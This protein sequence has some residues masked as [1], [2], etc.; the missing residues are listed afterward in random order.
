MPR[1]VSLLRTLVTFSAP[2]SAA[3][4]ILGAALA[5][6]CGSDSGT[7][8]VQP[9]TKE[10]G[11]DVNAGPAALEA[12]PPATIDAANRRDDVSSTVVFD[13]L[14][15]G[16]WTANGDVGSIAYSDI[17]H[18][19][20]LSEIAIGQNVTSV[21]L[22]PDYAWVAA[23]DRGAGTVA[24][25]DATAVAVRRTISLGTHPR[26]AVW[27][28]ADPRWLYV[29]MED[30][31]AVAVV[32]RTLGVLNHTVAVGRIPAGLAVSRLRRELTVMHRI[33]AAVTLLPLEG[34][35]AP[36]DQGVPP[37]DVPLADEPVQSDDTQ[38]SGKPFAFESLAWDPGGSVVWLPH[39]LLANHPPVQFQRNLFPAV[40]VVDLS[41]RS[42][43][44]T[45]PND[46]NGV[47]A[48]RKLLFSG[49]N[50]LDPTGNTSIVSQPCAAAI[51]PNGLVAYVVTC[52]SEDLLTFDVTSGIAI[53]LLRNLP[54]DHPTGLTLDDTG[55]RAFIVADQSHSLLTLDLAGGSPIGHARIIGGPLS[56]AA[57][58]PV[59]PELRA[60]LKL[61][62]EANSA[63]NALPT[64][65]NFW[66]S[67][68]GCHLD[69]FVSTNQRFF[70]AL[71]AL[72]PTTD[73]QIGHV[74]LTD[75]FST[76]PTPTSPTFN[77]H[78]VLVALLDQGGLVPD[79]TGASRTGEIDPANPTSDATTLAT[80]IARIVA[81]D[82]PAGPSWL[83]SDTG[84]L[85]ADYDAAWC[86]NC[87][88]AEFDAWQTSAHAHAGLDPMVKYGMGVEQTLRGTQYSRQCAGCHDPVSLR[89]GDSSLTSGCGI[90]CI[91]CHDTARL[92]R[93]GGN[94]DIEQATYDWTQDHKARASAQLAYLKTPQF[95][96]GCHQQFV[97]GT[98]IT[99]INTL[100]EWQSSPFAPAPAAPAPS[101]AGLGASS[102]LSTS[103]AGTTCVDCHMA[104]D[105]FGTHDHAAL[106][107]NVYVAQQFNQ[108]AIVPALTKR[109]ASAI[110]LHA[111]EGIDGVH[112]L[113][114]NIG[115]GHSF[116]TGVTD[117]REPWVEVQA[118]DSNHGLIARYGGPDA[119]GLV[120][121][122]AARLG[123][124][125][126]QAN[127]SLLY[128]HE[129]TQATRIPLM[130]LVPAQSTMEVVVSVP[131]T[132]PP[133][134][135]DLDAVVLYRNVRTQYYRAAT[136]DMTGT[137]PEVEVARIPVGE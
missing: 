76:A 36:A 25:V 41:A 37:V 83:V 99:A 17:D 55:Q 86:G 130:R 67:C 66:M 126:A 102:L 135:T 90:T 84:N 100:G 131:A 32:D 6:A 109:L 31:D 27:D 20:V 71:H 23:V 74:G 70:E 107:G 3:L 69:G 129:L 64:T 110:Q 2:L 1:D 85:N 72:D 101:D 119:S 40:S 50:V 92:I 19:K 89:L 24:L 46:P 81:R 10:A 106:G 30:D 35:Y 4:F 103:S 16:V 114:Q 88:K 11:P 52:A 8:P 22:S 125:I 5:S 51:H 97:P 29:S 93:A 47:I 122:D 7:P 128:H 78:D 13:R 59:D 104:D 82:L 120:P 132:L 95:C 38:P 87:H 48:G 28:A 137:A 124:D 56:L 65:G 61:F 57:K 58:D 33:D 91:G 113:V 73:A 34:V 112:V 21:A 43:V 18:Q 80:R 79:R 134:A 98:G 14:R 105:G 26:A 96:A 94:S 75:M 118:V 9:P 136:G 68:G 117:I 77:P 15:G 123:M 60:G 127:G 111:L 121:L 45:N 54:G 115:A 108:A 12:S 49:I 42:E 63:K 44:A 116:P 62:F 133:G 53:D 39:E